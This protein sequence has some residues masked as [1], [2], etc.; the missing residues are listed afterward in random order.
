MKD[1]RTWMVWGLLLFALSCTVAQWR[2]TATPQP[3]STPTLPPTATSDPSP[4]PLDPDTGWQSLD[5]GLEQRSLDVPLG[6]LTER[7]T[8]LRVDSAHARFRVIYAPGDPRLVSVWGE[9]TGVRVAIN[10]GYF[11]EAYEATGLII[12]EGERFGATYEDFAGMFTVSSQGLPDLRWLRQQPYDPV[13]TLAGAVQSFPLLVKPGGELGFPLSADNGARARRSV[14]AK[15]RA[16]CILLMVAPRGYFTLHELSAWLTASDLD[17]D[18]ALNLDG[19]P[20]TGLWAAAWARP[21]TSPPLD[22]LGPVPAVIA[23]E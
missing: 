19:G 7:V 17:I 9:Q 5:V 23:V 21:P 8:I 3:T 22:S 12:S 1:H 13:E 16:G 6:D 18:I 20:S 4:T 11:T 14:I 2:P 10:A 15:D